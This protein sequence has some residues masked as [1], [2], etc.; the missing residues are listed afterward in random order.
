MSQATHEWLIGL[1]KLTITVTA[2]PTLKRG[3]ATR[4]DAQKDMPTVLRVL[5]H[6]VDVELVLQ[7]GRIVIASHLDAG[8]EKKVDAALGRIVEAAIAVAAGGPGE[9]GS[10]ESFALEADVVAWLRG[11]LSIDSL[12]VSSGGAAR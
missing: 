10:Q 9:M 12:I 7:S 6:V 11:Q 5:R 2:I 3:D 4:L 1:S 8:I